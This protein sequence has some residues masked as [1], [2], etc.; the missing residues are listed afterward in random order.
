[1]NITKVESNEPYV[2]SSIKERHMHPDC[3]DAL[4]VQLLNS[5]V[6]KF[7]VNKEAIVRLKITVE[8]CDVDLER[9]VYNEKV[10]DE[11]ISN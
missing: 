7:K 10:E 1:M 11:K 6:K 9:L 4:L 2:V 5:A 8:S 3:E